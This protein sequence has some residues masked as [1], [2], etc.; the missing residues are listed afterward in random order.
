MKRTVEGWEAKRI[1]ERR[2][3]RRRLGIL[4]AVLG[5]L[6][7]LFLLV[8]LIRHQSDG[9]TGDEVVK[10]GQVGWGG[11]QTKMSMGKEDVGKPVG[12][13]SQSNMETT[14]SR[15]ERTVHAAMRTDRGDDDV[16]S[17]LRIFDEL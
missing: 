11:N 5:S 1:E 8:Y 16:D 12:K 7:G 15:A 6:V 10:M 14:A 2:R 13:F 9:G 3:N 4:W 17:R